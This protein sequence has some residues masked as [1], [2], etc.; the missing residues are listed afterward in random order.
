MQRIFNRIPFMVPLSYF[1]HLSFFQK[2]N[3]GKGS[4]SPTLAAIKNVVVV[5]NFL[6]L[7]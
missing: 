3:M 4:L 1:S 5:L 2:I 7:V 6:S